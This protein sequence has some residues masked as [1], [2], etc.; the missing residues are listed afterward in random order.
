MF[1]SYKVLKLFFWNVRTLRL[2]NFR[3]LP[4]RQ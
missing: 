4:E 2:W 3:T 1:E